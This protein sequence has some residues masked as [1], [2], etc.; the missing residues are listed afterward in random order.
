MKQGAI[1]A[2]RNLKSET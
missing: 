2:M 1:G